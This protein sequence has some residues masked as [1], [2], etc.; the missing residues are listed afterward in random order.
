MTKMGLGETLNIICDCHIHSFSKA[1]SSGKGSYSPP[2]MDL[3]DYE[4]EA[5]RNGI[6]RAVVVQASIDGT[7][8]SRL[9]DLLSSHAEIELRGVA[10]I[11]PETADLPYLHSAGIRAIRVQDRE[12]LGQSDLDKLPILAECAASTGWHVELNTEP[13]SFD[14]IFDHISCLP[15]STLLVLDHLGHVDPDSPEEIGKLFRLLDTGK[16]WVKLS[17]SRV[18]RRIGNYSDLMAMVTKIGT[19]YPEQCIWGSDWPH[20]MTKPPLP[21]ISPMLAFLK[22]ALN[23]EQFLACMSLNPERLYGF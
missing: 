3:D 16:V 17:P 11:N 18:S 10:T 8:N 2:N 23:E 15:E 5:S 4:P 7:D 22:E 14:T 12:R 1:P 6:K 19:D 21:E 20:V 9:I 13:R